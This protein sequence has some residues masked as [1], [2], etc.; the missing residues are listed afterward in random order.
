VSFD[1]DALGSGI[2]CNYFLS[3]TLIGLMRSFNLTFDIFYSAFGMVVC[4]KQRLRL[5][6]SD[7]INF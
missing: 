6:N 3:I 7:S 5:G 4:A 2:K 1:F